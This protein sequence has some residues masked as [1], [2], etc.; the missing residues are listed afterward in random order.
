MTID[1]FIRP[2]IVSCLL[3]IAVLSGGCSPPLP[4]AWLPLSVGM[5]EEIHPSIDRMQVVTA[6]R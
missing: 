5:L 1:R 2:V 4:K 6:P 3:S